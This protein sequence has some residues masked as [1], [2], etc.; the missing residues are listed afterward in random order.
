MDD[1]LFRKII[2]AVVLSTRGTCLFVAAL[3]LIPAN[4]SSTVRLG[5]L[6]MPLPL[7]RWSAPARRLT[8]VRC[9][10][11]RTTTRWLTSLSFVA[12]ILQSGTLPSLW[13][14]GGSHVSYFLGLA[15][16]PYSLSTS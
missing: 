15:T 6:R 3:Q 12:K 13:Y 14:G 2:A 5:V 11:L 1:D 10:G 9:S 4:V 16:T 7:T 8:A